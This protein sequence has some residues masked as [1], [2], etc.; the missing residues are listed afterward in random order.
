MRMITKKILPGALIALC[1]WLVAAD[2]VT[3]QTREEVREEF[4]QTYPLSAMGRVSVEN[5]NG[6][7]HLMGWDRN[8]V[9]VD[10]IKTA[11]TRER[12]AEAQIR[13]DATADSIRI[14]TEYPDQNLSFTNKEGRRYNNPASVE[15][16]ISVPR[17]ARIESVQLV[18]GA[19]DIEGVTGDVNASCVNGQIKARGLAGVTKL[20]TVN[21]RLE[22]A[23]DQLDESK[24]ITLGSVNG[25][26]VLI[27]PS[28][29][30]AE[31][32]ANTVHGGIKND[33]GL[34]VRDGEY[35]GHSLAGTLGRGGARIK[36]NNVNG[37]ITIRHAADGR[38]VSSATNLLPEKR[39]PD[40]VEMDADASATER[41]VNK[42]LK[43]DMKAEVRRE[44][45]RNK[46]EIER[47]VREAQRQASRELRHQQ[48][49]LERV[50]GEA[51][52]ETNR[53]HRDAE[54]AARGAVA[55]RAEIHRH[56]DHRLVA[57]ETKSF[58]VG[59]VPRVNV[60]TFDGSITVRAWD[61]PEVAVT[62]IK[63][64]TDENEMRGIRLRTE[65][66][67]A[68]IFISAEFDRAYAQQVNPGTLSSNASVQLELSVPRQANL[69]ATSGDGS[70]SV[71]NVKGEMN[72]RTGDGSIDVRDSSGRLVAN[73]GDGAVRI[74]NFDGEA[75]AR[76]GD[77]RISLDGRFAQLAAHTSAGSIS[78]A[79]PANTDAT[80]QTQAE[81]VINDGLA[82]AED[83]ASESRLRRWRVGRGGSN[84]LK[85]QTGAGRII[86]HR[87][88]STPSTAN[89]Q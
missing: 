77:G 1:V 24:I 17:A 64:A 13:V 89:N 12:L 75:E 86:L 60:E 50:P 54:R 69:R 5:I 56:M 51:E 66:R 70:L 48:R 37:A 31:V 30:N 33:F 35:V 41:R 18:N 44:I 45:E 72:V 40:S 26:I 39:A 22:A 73:T 67:G 78:L 42:D 11:Y 68:E 21:G 74:I 82:V 55:A 15:Y 58:T 81:R 10:A 61:R 28:D 27:I 80:I 65:Q 71:V 53:I 84:L 49:E 19:L 79:L 23:F 63:R 32:R 2:I 16:T 46:A 59:G 43:H 6:A 83:D 36:L 20:S 34:P 3:S 38:P 4:H 76:T 8:E 9:K 7:V 88:D 14:R 85:L 29:A 57:R 52:G 87:S 47:A 62:A 25:Q